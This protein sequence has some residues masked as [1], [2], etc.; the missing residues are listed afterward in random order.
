MTNYR[1][2]KIEGGTYFFTLVTNQRQTWLCT[3]IARPL[4][5]SAFIKVRKQYPFAI[6]ILEEQIKISSSLTST[7]LISSESKDIQ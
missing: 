5:R 4:L 3:D 7:K 1:R 6:A 2:C